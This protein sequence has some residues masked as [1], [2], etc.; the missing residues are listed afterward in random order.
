[1]KRNILLFGIFGAISGFFS[2]FSLFND[3]ESSKVYKTILEY[4]PGWIFGITIS[5][6][7]YFRFR[8]HIFF[9]ILYVAISTGAFYVA[10][11][12]FSYFND[13]DGGGYQGFF[14]AGLVGS[15][16]LT[17]SLRFVYPIS[18]KHMAIIVA[19][20]AVAG[21]PADFLSVFN[22]FVTWQTAVAI[23]ICY[24]INESMEVSKKTSS[25]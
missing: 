24:A 2:F 25:I 7:L 18:F 6:L 21:L 10:M 4:G 5:L 14:M 22:I 13:F 9:H 12:V 23:A 1:M 11:K 20:G 8:K 16:I 19:V 15:S 17:T 3:L